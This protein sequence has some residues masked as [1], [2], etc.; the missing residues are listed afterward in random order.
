M[1]LQHAQVSLDI[2]CL[3]LPRDET[4]DIIE[5]QGGDE[6]TNQLASPANDGECCVSIAMNFHVFIF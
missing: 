4:D 5:E 6:V 3:T 1:D 2:I